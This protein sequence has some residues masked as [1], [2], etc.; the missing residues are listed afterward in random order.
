MRR[1]R[2]RRRLLQ[3][4]RAAVEDQHIRV[5]DLLHHELAHVLHEQLERRRLHEGHDLVEH[6][7]GGQHV[8]VELFHLPHAVVLDDASLA[9]VLVEPLAQIGARKLGLLLDIDHEKR[10][11]RRTC[12]ART[13][14]RPPRRRSAAFSRR[15]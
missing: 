1:L 12:R 11:A 6:P 14:P 2:A 5:G 8:A 4:G 9:V 15:C 13:P 3:L 7:V 10:S